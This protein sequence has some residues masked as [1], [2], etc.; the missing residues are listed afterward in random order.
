MLRLNQ[1]MIFALIAMVLLSSNGVL[2][3]KILPGDFLLTHST[4]TMRSKLTREAL[5]RLAARNIHHRHKI[6]HSFLQMKLT[7]KQKYWWLPDFL[8]E[9]LEPPRDDSNEE[10]VPTQSKSS[11]VS[12]NNSIESIIDNRNAEIRKKNGFVKAEDWDKQQANILD[13]DDGSIAWGKK[14]Q[15]DGLRGGDKMKQDTILRKNLR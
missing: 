6:K 5:P 14:A 9:K 12:E 1:L 8:L 7:D 11:F 2:S 3:F 15:F 13:D 4:L 10:S